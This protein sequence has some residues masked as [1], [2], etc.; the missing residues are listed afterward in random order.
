MKHEWMRELIALRLY[1]EVEERD[2]LEEHLEGCADC[3]R[4]AQE[5]ESGLGT[6]ARA[7]LAT[8]RAP[9]DDGLPADWTARLRE[10]TRPPPRA[11]WLRPWWTAVAGFAAGVVAAAVI[12]R[13][14][15]GGTPSGP[16]PEA[17]ATTWERFHGEKAPPLAKTEGQIRRLGEYRK[18]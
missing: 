15:L 16:P 13:G 18:R 5:L 2:R 12:D 9:R 11:P 8:A 4:F 17:A 3:R 1:G 7:S 10:A 6:L 14:S